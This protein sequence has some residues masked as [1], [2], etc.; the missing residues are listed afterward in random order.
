MAKLQLPIH[1]LGL[2]LHLLMLERAHISSNLSFIELVNSEFEQISSSW[3]INFS[4]LSMILET[5]L[6]SLG[7][8]ISSISR[9]IEFKFLKMTTPRTQISSSLKFE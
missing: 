6:P 3:N 5:S 4:S 2:N 9:F 7:S 1:I 8:N